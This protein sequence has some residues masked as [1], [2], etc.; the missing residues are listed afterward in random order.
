[1]SDK[2]S[3]ELLRKARASVRLGW[4]CAALI[5]VVL[6][7]ELVF[8]AATPVDVLV[9]KWGSPRDLVGLHWAD[10]ALAISLSAVAGAIGGILDWLVTEIPKAITWPIVAL[11]ALLAILRSWR[12]LAWL[13]P[14][15]GR[16]QSLKL[17]TFEVQLSEEGAKQLSLS[18]QEVF[19]QY[20]AQADKEFERQVRLTH[21][22]D[23][24]EQ[25][26]QA[27]EIPDP[28]GT[29][30]RLLSIPNFRCTIHVADIL[31][32]EIFTNSSSTTRAQKADVRVAASPSATA[33][34][35][36]LGG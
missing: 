25:V 31:F 21:L 7:F 17:G 8:L 14:V 1:M 18:A 10:D 4:V 6:V 34:L 15:F 16:F 29:P 2:T 22:R 13:L 20:R 26:V 12:A 3:Q 23:R 33:L 28:S 24:L 36:E 5:T 9:T 11:I 30:R 32:A 35:A 27:T 19:A